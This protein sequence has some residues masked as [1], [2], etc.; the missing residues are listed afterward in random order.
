MKFLALLIVPL[1]LSSHPTRGGW[2]EIG[3]VDKLMRD[4][5]SHPTRGG[6]IEIQRSGMVDKLM[7]GP[8]PHG[9]GGLKW[10]LATHCNNVMAVPPHTGRVD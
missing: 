9:V 3:M 1:I 8:T 10:A 6:W 5:W 7:R 4:C 2:I